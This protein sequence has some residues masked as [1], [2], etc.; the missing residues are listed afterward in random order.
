M[1]TVVLEKAERKKQAADDLIEI[2]AI[3]AKL[4]DKYVN[5]LFVYVLI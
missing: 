2:E 3:F 4:K 5:G 1:L